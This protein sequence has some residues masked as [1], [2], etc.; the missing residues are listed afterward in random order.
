MNKVTIY[1]FT[2]PMMGLTYESE[3]F[4]RQLETHFGDQVALKFV[5]AS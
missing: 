1:H 4:F 3:P 2:D 5:M